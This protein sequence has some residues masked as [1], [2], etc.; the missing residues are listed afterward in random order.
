MSTGGRSG[1]GSTLSVSPSRSPARYNRTRVPLQ[2]QYLLPGTVHRQP[3]SVCRVTRRHHP[4]PSFAPDSLRLALSGACYTDHL[5]HCQGSVATQTL[6]PS[7]MV[8]TRSQRIPLSSLSA[9]TLHS[10]R[11]TASR[12]LPAVPQL[13]CTGSLCREFTPDVVQCVAVGSDGVGGLEWKCEADLPSGL[14]FG[15]VD[16]SC[17]GW[18]GPN[19]PNIL[20]GSCGLR[21]SLV[22]ASPSFEQ[23]YDSYKSYLPGRSSSLFNDAFNLLFSALTIYLVGS[24]VWKILRP[25]FGRRR[26]APPTQPRS[27]PRTWPWW[28][29][30]GGGGPGSGGA[31]GPGSGNSGPPPPYTPKANSD[32]S[33]GTG[34]GWRPGFWT[35]AAAGW[36]ANAFLGTGAGAAERRRNLYGVRGGGGVGY[37]GEDAAL[38]RGGFWGGGAQPPLGGTRGWGGW[39]GAPAGP[40][41]G[42]RRGFARDDDDDR[43]VGTSGMRRSTGFGGTSVR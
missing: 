28:N 25:C 21:Y 37:E 26:P 36:I 35:G 29:G 6:S 42:M 41:G 4:N 14:R 11:R 33:T 3:C 5:A 15:E 40:M 27:P 10:N 2:G 24:L 8:N 38:R 30:W 7:S 34:T 12:R 1:R 22:K 19:D 13:A 23:G 17:E 31:G 18:D 9:L 43:G 20:R 32:T 39:G 16:V